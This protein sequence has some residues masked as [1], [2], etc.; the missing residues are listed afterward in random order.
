MKICSVFC[1]ESVAEINSAL[2]RLEGGGDAPPEE[3]KGTEDGLADSE[4]GLAE[5]SGIG[6]AV[7]C[8]KHS[9]AYTS[10]DAKQNIITAGAGVMLY[11]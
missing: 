4:A 9:G 11:T 8:C 6:G 2:R 3:V 5:G 7:A 1:V 10:F